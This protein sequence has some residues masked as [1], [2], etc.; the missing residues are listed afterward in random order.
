MAT[1]WR[2]A[3][4][5]LVWGQMRS[6][7]LR[8]S[9]SQSRPRARARPATARDKLPEQ[10]RRCVHEP[11]FE[12]QDVA[13]VG[14]VRA[15]RPG[16]STR[17]PASAPWCPPASSGP[18]RARHPRELDGEAHVVS[19][20]SF[21]EAQESR[22]VQ[23]QRPVHHQSAERRSRSVQA[24]HRLRQRAGLRTRGAME[25]WRTRCTCSRR[26]TSKCRPRSAAGSK[27]AVS[28]TE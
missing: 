20:A 9:R 4:T 25:W 15:W 19:P 3:M 28:T 10:E 21:N 22:Q 8:R 27:S 12:P 5:Y 2:R 26:A 17:R 24:S 16:P 13:Y 18:G 6:T 1:V 14:S 11:E 23:G 7:R